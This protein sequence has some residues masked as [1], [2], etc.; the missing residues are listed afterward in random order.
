MVLILGLK[1]GICGVRILEDFG[2]P[3][4]ETLNRMNRGQ[5]WA[6]FIY[7]LWL[8]LAAEVSKNLNFGP[9]H[10]SNTGHVPKP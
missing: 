8:S 5:P 4:L 1:F 7:L 10:Y 3:N 6:H 9:K 2:A